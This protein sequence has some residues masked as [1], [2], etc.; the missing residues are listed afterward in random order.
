MNTKTLDKYTEIL[1]KIKQLE[2]EK[3]ALNAEIVEEMTK[4]G[5]SNSKTDN[6][7]FVLKFR[8][9]WDYSTETTFMGEQFKEA[10]KREE[11]NGEATIAKTT[12]YLMFLAKKEEV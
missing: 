8:K 11:N 7:E 10:K 4:E 6:G 1:N 12:E 2:Q 9:T 5:I 3:D